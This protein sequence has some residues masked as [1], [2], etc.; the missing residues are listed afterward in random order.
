MNC[1]VDLGADGFQNV[2]REVRAAHAADHEFLAGF[3]LVRVLYDRLVF[4]LLWKI[5]YR[6]AHC[7]I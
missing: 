3:K 4:K 5:E 6:V 2:G 7:H 1:D